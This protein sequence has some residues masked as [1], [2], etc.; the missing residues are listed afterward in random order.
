MSAHRGRAAAR[1]TVT[2]RYWRSVLATLSA[3]CG[4]GAAFAT[5]APPASAG[6]ALAPHP[7][8]TAFTTLIPEPAAPPVRLDVPAGTRLADAITYRG[9][10]IPI[11]GTVGAPCED[12]RPVVP[13]DGAYLDTCI[14]PHRGV[15]YVVG[16][17][18]GPFMPLRSAPQGSA[19][20]VWDA[21]GVPHP[22]HVL[23]I[24]TFSRFVPAPAPVAGTHVE[25]QTCATDDAS[26]LRVLDLG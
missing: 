21:D 25:L 15:D 17:A 9:A 14:T 5:T 7:P 2:R 8:I 23:A 1:V 10:V 18:P 3:G 19:V 11:A 16:H 20:A 6:P 13:R 24:H 4:L 12:V 26:V 22:F